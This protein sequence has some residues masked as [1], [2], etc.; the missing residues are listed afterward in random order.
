MRMAEELEKAVLEELE[1]AE[2][3]DARKGQQACD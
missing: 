2:E 1:E 3:G